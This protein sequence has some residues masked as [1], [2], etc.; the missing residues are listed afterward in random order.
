MVWLLYHVV[1]L[2]INFAAAVT[3]SSV[4]N[5][6]S[7]YRLGDIIS[8]PA[9]GCCLGHQSIAREMQLQYPES[10]VS[11]Y[12]KYSDN[13]KNFTA[14]E[15]ALLDV[16]PSVNKYPTVL[17]HI[18][19]GDVVCGSS[20]HEI[21]KRPFPPKLIAKAILP[22]KT[23]SIGLCFNFHH[24]AIT[25]KCDKESIDY[26][27]EIKRLLPSAIVFQ[28]SAFPDI[29]LCAMANAPLFVGGKGFF[30]RTVFQLRTFRGMPSIDLTTS[31]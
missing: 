13:P 20:W 19:L 8:H 17:I 16:C 21:E 31:V 12:L 6:S 15:L 10:I 4:Y 23:L 26:L 24:G 11:R 22:F 14:L 1:V 5:E 9:G 29:H 7:P 18:R 30:S 27:K 3:A 25:S 28:P 2:L